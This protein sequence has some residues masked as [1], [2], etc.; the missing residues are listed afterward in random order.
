MERGCLWRTAGGLAG[1]ILGMITLTV[2]LSWSD[3]H[4]RPLG[5]G[6]P[7]DRWAQSVVRVYLFYPATFIAGAAAGAAGASAAFGDPADRRRGS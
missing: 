1:G 4:P 6:D 7:I 5:G 2:W 3:H